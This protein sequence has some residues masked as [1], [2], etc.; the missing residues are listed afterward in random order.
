L[1]LLTAGINDEY[2][3]TV[4]DDN[5]DIKYNTILEILDDLN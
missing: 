2:F 1:G 5:I 4:I 3:K